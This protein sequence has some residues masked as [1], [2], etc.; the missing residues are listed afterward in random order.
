MT[1]RQESLKEMRVVAVRHVGPYPDIGKAFDKLSAWA[2]PRGAVKA[3]SWMIGVYYDDANTVSPE[4]LRSDAA[5][6]TDVAADPKAGIEERKI[7]SGRYVVQS[8]RGP[9]SGLGAAWQ[10]LIGKHG[11][12]IDTRP[13][14]ERYLNTPADTVPQDLMTELYLPI[15]S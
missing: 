8:Y 6:V 7:P 2:G 5:L 4:K 14:F 9:Y 11:A 13:C 1:E 15:R 10:A 12:Q 3:G